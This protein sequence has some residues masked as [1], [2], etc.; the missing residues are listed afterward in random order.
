M[1]LMH[2]DLKD[3]ILKN[4][5]IDEFHPKT[6]DLRDVCSV[7]FYVAHRPAG[8]D[9]YDFLQRGVVKFRDIE[10]TPNPTDENMYMVFIELDR[11]E[12]LIDNIDYLVS[13]ISN[14]AGDLQWQYK[15][16][17]MDTYHPWSDR[18]EIMTDPT[19]FMNIDQYLEKQAELQKQATQ[20]QYKNSIMEFFKQSDLHDV[21]LEQNNLS[22]TGN[23][24]SAQLE[25]VGF[26]PGSKMLTQ[27]GISESAIDTPSSEFKKFQSML[28]ELR[29]V[30]IQDHIVMFYPGSSKVLVTRPHKY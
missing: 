25:V 18:R 23:N 21:T 26:G 3:T 2:G 9:L 6:G 29:A 30:P 5:S 17:V 14:L 16:H 12:D 7:G 20:E 28:G 27:A 10:L 11:N 15:T 22:L 4:I 19:T 1:S 24:H 13:D 8:G